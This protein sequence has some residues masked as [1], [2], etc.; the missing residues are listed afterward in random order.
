MSISLIDNL[1]KYI[2]EYKKASILVPSGKYI[3]Q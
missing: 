2:K 3:V 1:L